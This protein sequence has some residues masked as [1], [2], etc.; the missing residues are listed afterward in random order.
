MRTDFDRTILMHDKLNKIWN[1]D[2]LMN[3]VKTKLKNCKYKRYMI[4]QK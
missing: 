4:N 3:E 2:I 1:D